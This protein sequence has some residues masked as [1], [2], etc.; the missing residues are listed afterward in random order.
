MKFFISFPGE[1]VRVLLPLAR[2][3]ARSRYAPPVEPA[4]CMNGQD[5]LLLPAYAQQ[6]PCIQMC[7]VVGLYVPFSRNVLNMRLQGGL[8]DAKRFR[9]CG[10]VQAIAY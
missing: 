6:A 5:R 8:S 1:P 9:N 4:I 7:R 2:L 10:S 3:K